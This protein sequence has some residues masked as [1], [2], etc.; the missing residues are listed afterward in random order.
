MDIVAYK[1]L[2][3]AESME[4]NPFA[5]GE[6]RFAKVVKPEPLASSEIVVVDPKWGGDH[7]LRHLY[8]SLAG[9]ND[10]PLN[11]MYPFESVKRYR[12]ALDAL[13]GDKI[14]I[15]EESPERPNNYICVR[16]FVARGEGTRDFESTNALGEKRVDKVP[17]T[18]SVPYGYPV[19]KREDLLDVCKWMHGNVPISGR[20]VYVG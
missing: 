18:E 17:V 5:I 16:M 10:R 7:S 19:G 2:D 14:V 1:S 11:T 3:E 6:P 20:P 9:Y 4:F 13:V 15:V 8:V 12:A